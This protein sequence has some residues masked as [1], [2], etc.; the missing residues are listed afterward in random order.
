[1]RSIL[2]ALAL[3]SLSPS[4]RPIMYREIPPPSSL[5]DYVECFWTRDLAP[6]EA[7]GGIE[8]VL[9]DGCVD[10]VMEIGSSP[11]PVAVGTMTKP[12]LLAAR[13]PHQFLGVRFRPGRAYAML[14]IP[15]FELT[16]ARVPLSDVWREVDPLL[17]R[18]L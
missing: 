1:M 12:L 10:F 4:H 6:A 3:S 8:R 17:D 9:P 7:L 13:S 16:D 5:A 11:A 18:I 2:A 14:G 15:A